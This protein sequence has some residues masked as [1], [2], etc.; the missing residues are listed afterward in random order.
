MS[1]MSFGA[2]TYGW[3]AP[4]VFDPSN[5]AVMYAG[6]NKVA[7]S[8]NGGATW[9]A[10]SPVLSPSSGKSGYVY[11]TV[12]AIAVAKSDAKTIWAGLDDG[13]VWKTTT[14]GSPWTRIQGLPA[15]Y[16]T[17]ITI[18]D[19]DANTVYAAFSGYRNGDSVARLMRTTDGGVTW[20][21][22]SGD[23]P[24]ATV[25]DVVLLGDTV[26]AGTDVGVYV[27]HDGGAHWLAVGSGLPVA[28]VTDLQLN[29]G[30]GRLYVSTF[31]RGF[32]HIPSAALSAG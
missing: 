2:G 8:T 30:T 3:F 1:S 4:M 13:R 17:R 9:T 31:G 12:T 11:G 10:I 20:T 18:S 7:R 14:T 25:N 26:V 21:D 22:I 16:V 6:G 24:A 15:N 29:K 28:A 27:T 23:L 5:P 19:T 32:W